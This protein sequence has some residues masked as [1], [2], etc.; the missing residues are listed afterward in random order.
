MQTVDIAAFRISGAS[1]RTNNA[2]EASGQGRIGQLWQ[3]Y[4]ATASSA[5][6]GA[7]AYGVYSDYESD[8]SGDY[9]LT[10]GSRDNRDNRDSAEAQAAANGVTVQVQAGSYLAFRAQGQMP[11]AVVQAWQTIWAHFAAEQADALPYVRVYGTDFEHYDAPDSA[12]IYIGIAPR[13][14]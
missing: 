6:A 7:Q 2:L 5:V 12:V 3:D 13:Q 8:A 4:A 9:R 10:V 14:P 1:I 11:R